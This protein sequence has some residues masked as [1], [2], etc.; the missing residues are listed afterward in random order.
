ML[1]QYSWWKYLI[2]G[3]VIVIGAVYALPNLFDQDPA[4]QISP[5]ARTA[6][7][8]QNLFIRVEG[9]LKEEQ[10]SYKGLELTEDRLLVRFPDTEVQLKAADILK[11][12]LG[13]DFVVALNLAPTT[14]K[15]MQN[16]SL[17]PM[18]LGLDLR[19]V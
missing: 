10:I 18:Y 13:R 16:L 14:P 4:V 2:I 1:N 17:N 9:K 6:V 11:D 7:V 12:V 5:S 19:A 15:F 3:V 8:D